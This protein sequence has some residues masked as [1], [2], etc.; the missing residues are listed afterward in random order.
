MK[1]FAYLL[2]CDRDSQLKPQNLFFYVIRRIFY[3]NG[4][5]QRVLDERELDDSFRI[6]VEVQVKGD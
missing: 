4:N 6:N 1:V 5:A 2:S 3:G